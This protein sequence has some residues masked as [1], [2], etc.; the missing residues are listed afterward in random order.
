MACS[1]KVGSPEIDKSNEKIL[2]LDKPCEYCK[3]LLLDEAK[4]SEAVRYKY[5]GEGYL[6]F[7]NIDLFEARAYYHHF[8][9]RSKRRGEKVLNLRL[10]LGYKR[11]DTLPNLP[12]LAAT[13]SQGCAFC[14]ILRRD[15]ISILPKLGNA[16]EGPTGFGDSGQIKLIITEIFYRLGEYHPTEDCEHQMTTLDSLYV[17]FTIEVGGEPAGNHSLHY[18]VYAEASDP[19]ATWFNIQKRPFSNRLLSASAVDRLC[20]LI[21]QSSN[22]SALEDSV[23]L[24]TRLLDVGSSTEPCLRLVQMKNYPQLQPA[25][26]NAFVKKYAAISYCW[27]A[28]EEADKQLKTTRDTLQGHLSEVELHTMPQT[29]ADAVKL[30]RAIGLRYLWVDALCII[31]DDDADWTRESFEMSNIYANSFITLCVVTGTSCSTG[32]LDRLHNPNTLQINFNSQ[33]DSSVKGKLFLRMYKHPTLDLITEYTKISVFD[34]LV[35]DD[36]LEVDRWRSENAPWFQRGWTFQESHFSKRKLLIGDDMAYLWH[37]DKIVS[38]DGTRYERL[39]PAL[40]SHKSMRDALNQWYTMIIFYVR[41]KLSYERD[42]L[43]ALSGLS[44]ALA[45]SF[46][47]LEYL[48]GL[49]KADLHTGLMWISRTT[50][51]Y[52]DYIKPRE[53]G[54]VAPSWSWARR[55]DPVNWFFVD[56]EHTPE[57]ELRAANVVTDKLNPYGRVFS[58]YLELNAKMYK[59][60]PLGEEGEDSSSS[61]SSRPCINKVSEDEK[62]YW[63]IYPFHYVLYSKCG[64][65]VAT[66]NLDWDEQ[67]FLHDG[68]G[69]LD[70]PMDEMR[71]LLISSSDL[72]DRVMRQ[73]YYDNRMMAG[74]LVM[75]TQ[76]AD[77]F[78]RVGLWYSLAKGLGGRKF[79][80]DVQP[81]IIRLV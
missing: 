54:Y 62:L 31:Q 13:A 68:Y 49:W 25:A 40:E 44:R 6:F 21:S 52:Q 17:Y 47:D 9:L 3:L 56:V 42:R 11:E 79:W 51:T 60:V 28:K 64:N 71:M 43:P 63:H 23:Y 70:A 29:V 30:C 66:L 50:Q 65:Y 74:L 75:P 18:N 78:V 19:C 20:E 16:L 45:S 35:R 77:E 69:Y 58:A 7:G 2:L 46:P 36:T 34:G 10:N 24:P 57:F 38:M 55:P 26:A 27:G 81:Q 12:N 53:Y 1:S 14:D 4:H 73:E 59:M 33:I 72:S 41:R 48:A 61:S 32:F 8:T 39:Q 15:I 80:E 76:N 22:E 67:G 5:N 37:E